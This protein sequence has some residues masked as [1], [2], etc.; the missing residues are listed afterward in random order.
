MKYMAVPI[1]N[2]TTSTTSIGEPELLDSAEERNAVVH[3]YNMAAPPDCWIT[4]FPPDQAEFEFSTPG[5][6]ERAYVAGLRFVLEH[7]AILVAGVNYQLVD[8]FP[9]EI[10]RLEA[11]ATRLENED[12]PVSQDMEPVTDLPLDEI[13]GLPD[14]GDYPFITDYPIGALGD[15]TGKVAPTRS[16]RI[17]GYD[18][19]KYCDVLVY[20]ETGVVRTGI[21]RGYIYRPVTEQEVAVLLCGRP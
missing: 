10:V 12:R 21:K 8:R 11:W 14:D 2:D 6:Y 19:N 7:P 4:T 18:G 15:L 1:L 9:D 20:G 16:C 5:V 17:I 13:V 3:G